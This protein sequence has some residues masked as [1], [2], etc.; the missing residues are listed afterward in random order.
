MKLFL[1]GYIFISFIIFLYVLSFRKSFSKE[2]ENEL[3]NSFVR[4]LRRMYYIVALFS[5]DLL[6]FISSNFSTIITII[7]NLLLRLPLITEMLFSF[8]IQSSLAVMFWKYIQLPV[9]NRE[10]ENVEGKVTRYFRGKK[11]LLRYQR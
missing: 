10:G 2:N 6:I 5:P 7:S 8:S 11:A 9:Y 3:Q 1:K 4:N